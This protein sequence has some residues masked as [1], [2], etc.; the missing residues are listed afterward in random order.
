MN[1]L[2]YTLLAGGLIGAGLIMYF[3]PTF[4][5][6]KRKHRDV[7]LIALVNFFLGWTVAFWVVCLIWATRPPSQAVIQ[8]P[9]PLPSDR[10]CQACGTGMKASAK[11]CPGCGA[12]IAGTPAP[13]G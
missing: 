11:F 10:Y 1:T 3:L 7:Q 6:S 13:V 5:A 4:V 12:A 8:A 9:V 2:G